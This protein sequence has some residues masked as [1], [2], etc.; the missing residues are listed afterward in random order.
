M[1]RLACVWADL[2]DD[3]D[4]ESFY[5]DT[6]IPNVVAKLG[7]TAR[8]AEITE[9]NIFKE[10]PNI[11]GKYMTLYDVPT[12]SEATEI[13]AQIQPDA[14]ELPKSTKA[15]ARIYGEYAGWFGEEWDGRKQISAATTAS[16][17]G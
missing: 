14:L 16:Y 8:N 1:S 11:E 15:E 10:V 4:A 17:V 7:I 3:N 5:E 9:E 12:S 6:H 13:D 2:A